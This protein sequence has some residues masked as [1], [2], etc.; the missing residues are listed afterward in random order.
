MRNASRIIILLICLFSLSIIFIG[1]NKIKIYKKELTLYSDSLRTLKDV[2]AEDISHSAKKMKINS[3]KVIDENLDTIDMNEIFKLNETK[4]ILR[5][6]DYQCMDCIDSI[7]KQL[8][9]FTQSV[10]N[11]NIVLFGSFHSTSDLIRLKSVRKIPFKVYNLISKTFDKSID[12]MKLPYLFLTDS[13]LLARSFFFYRVDNPSITSIYLSV[14]KKYF[15]NKFSQEYPIINEKNSSIKFER[16]LFDFGELQYLSNATALFKYVNTSKK[17]LIITLVETGCGCT[18]ATYKRTAIM[19]GDSGVISFQYD[20]K[21]TG[22]FDRTIY[23]Y[24]NAIQSP[25]LVKIKGV[26]KKTII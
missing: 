22:Y 18:V 3:Q 12:N 6:N 19:S 4:L 13:T 21:R 5:I 24:S 8:E 20:T 10:G 26:V 23:I 16:E 11:E 9:L 14:L 1:L 17:P 2:F 15:L 25:N 7:L